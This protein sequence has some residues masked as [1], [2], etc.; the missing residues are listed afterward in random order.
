MCA[1]K[2]EKSKKIPLFPGRTRKVRAKL[3]FGLN[4]NLPWEDWKFLSTVLTSANLR[5][6]LIFW[7]KG[8]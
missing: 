7:W 4:R 2:T 3:K 6:L 8:S 1:R 5:T